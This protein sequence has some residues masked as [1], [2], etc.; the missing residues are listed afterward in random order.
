MRRVLRLSELFHR[1]RTELVKPRTPRAQAVSATLGR[2]MGADVLP[3]P[4]DVQGLIPQP[5]VGVAWVR[6]VVGVRLWIFFRF[7]EDE[8]EV[9]AMTAVEPALIDE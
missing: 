8:V 3:G 1:S 7:D 9:L 6:Q 2:L 4:L 5:Q